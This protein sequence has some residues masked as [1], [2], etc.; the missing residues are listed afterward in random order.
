MDYSEPDEQLR[1]VLLVVVA[2]LVLVVDLLVVGD[3]PDELV[4]LVQQLDGVARLVPDYVVRYEGQ[5]LD[6]L[7]LNGKLALLLLRLPLPGQ[8]CLLEGAEY[9]PGYVDHDRPFSFEGAEDVALLLVVDELVKEEVDLFDHGLPA[10]YEVVE[11]VEGDVE[12]ALEDILLEGAALAQIDPVYGHLQN[13]NENVPS[14]VEQI[15]G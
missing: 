5:W 10:E 7:R 3:L 4:L 8:G 2:D 12:V 1:L 13:G 15:K 11:V 6:V 14:G 9:L